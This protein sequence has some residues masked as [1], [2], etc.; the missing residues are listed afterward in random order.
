MR[1]RGAGGAVASAK[2]KEG[3]MKFYSEQSSG[4]KM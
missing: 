3:V 2:E 1:N 4:I